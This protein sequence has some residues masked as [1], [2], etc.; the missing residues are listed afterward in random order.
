MLHVLPSGA[1][2][3]AYLAKTHLLSRSLVLPV[4]RYHNLSVSV[5]PS[6]KYRE[7]KHHLFSAPPPPTSSSTMLCYSKDSSP[8]VYDWKYASNSEYSEFSFL[9]SSREWT[10]NWFVYSQGRGCLD[11]WSKTFINVVE[12]VKIFF[13]LVF[14]LLK[15]W[16]CNCH[17]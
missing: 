10:L 16:L 9:V 17:L 7:L 15:Q 14:M 6:C 13:F 4:S 3:P 11:F 1:R 8:A 2:V 5:A 12:K